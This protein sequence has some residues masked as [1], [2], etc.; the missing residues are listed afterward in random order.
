MH[1]TSVD[2]V[3]GGSGQDRPY[4]SG[5]LSLPHSH[6]VDLFKS[7]FCCLMACESL[8]FP[9]LVNENIEPRGLAGSN[10][11]TTALSLGLEPCLESEVNR[12]D[13]RLPRGTR[14]RSR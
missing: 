10:T 9:N 8:S 4:S 5:S 13:G 14:G 6:M 1:P 7:Q 11:Q 2:R 3:V 12:Q